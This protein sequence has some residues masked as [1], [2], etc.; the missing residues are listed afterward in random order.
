MLNTMTLYNTTKLACKTLKAHGMGGGHRGDVNNNKPNNKHTN[1][2]L[3]MTFAR[4][5][6]K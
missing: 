6:Q 5:V 4:V 1:G 2:S 3:N